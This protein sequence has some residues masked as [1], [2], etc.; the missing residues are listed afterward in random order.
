MMKN[1]F[2]LLPY[3]MLVLI[4]GIYLGIQ[5]NNY[6][7]FSGNKKQI[8]KFSEVLNYTQFYYV[9]SVNTKNLVEDAI[10]GMFNK[11]DPHTVYISKEEQTIDEETFRGNFDGIGVEFQIVNDTITV[12]SPISGGPSEAVGILSGDRIIKIDGKNS[13][14][15]KNQDVIKK[16]RG[17]KGVSVDLTIFRPSS[18]STNNYKVIRDKINLYSVDASLMFDDATGYINLTRFSETT[19]NE[20]KKALQELSSMGMKKLIL[21][22]RNNP[23][24]YENQAA[25]VADLFLDENKLIVFNKGR[26]NEFNEEFRSGKRYP[27]EKIPLIILVNR[28]SASASEIVSGAIQDWDRGLIVGETTF[29]KGL[30][31]RPIELSDGSAVRITIAKYYTPSGRPIQRDYK[32]KTK[33]YKDVMVRQELDGNNI[34]HKTE[35][36]SS[37]PKYKT[38]NGRIVYGG[39][40]ITPDYIIESRSISE[41]FLELRRNNVYYQFV[42][43]YMDKNGNILNEKYQNDLKKFVEEFQFNDDQ[44]QDFIKY[45][46]SLKVKYDPKGFS[47]DKELIRANLKAFVARDLFKNNGWYSTLL[48]SDRQFQK[49]ISLFG[50]AEKLNGFSK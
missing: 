46:V 35:K 32:D 27:Y 1:I 44:L 24:G 41:Y 42:R 7:S 19:T 39:G 50:E 12:V 33:Y 4:I 9:D 49:A 3:F 23:G 28:G 26:V 2:K 38:K 45:A 37:K 5:I 30:V 15:W 36:D 34:E 8:D 31:Q 17:R 13:I 14:G 10:K 25:N 11:L 16:L 20:M 47:I 48:K 22:L 40:G 21:D 43:R 6:L 18:K 29:G